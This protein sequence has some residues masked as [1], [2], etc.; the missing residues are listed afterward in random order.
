MTEFLGG[1][2]SV[3]GSYP[4]WAYKKDS[5]LRH[6]VAECYKEQ[7]GQEPVVESIHAGLECGLI[8][9]KMPDLDIVALGADVKDIHTPDERLSISSMERT[10]RLLIHILSK[11]K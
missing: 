10:Y 2:Y 1:D 3:S 8:L 5:P 7:Y 4:E 9:E 6:L 11:I